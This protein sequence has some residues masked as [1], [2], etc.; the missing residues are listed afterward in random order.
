MSTEIDKVYS[1]WESQFILSTQ[2][3][4]ELSEKQI[5]DFKQKSETKVISNYSENEIKLAMFS[6]YLNKTS[7]LKD[8]LE[9][10]SSSEK[11]NSRENRPIN[12]KKQKSK[13][14]KKTK[15]FDSSKLKQK[16]KR[17]AKKAFD[18]K[19]NRKA[20]L[21]WKKEREE[22]NRLIKKAQL[23]EEIKGIKDQEITKVIQQEGYKNYER[24]INQEKEENFEKFGQRLT[25]REIKEMFHREKDIQSV[26]D[27]RFS[28][29][30]QDKNYT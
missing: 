8:I 28:S 27:N 12:L 24:I 6:A 30:P 29:G 22:R 18:P 25:N 9:I 4:E 14:Y 21:K 26:L 15:I 23:R 7:K 2:F 10:L 20:E 5:T 3:I 19:P 13:N 1:L 17:T 11:Q 16:Q